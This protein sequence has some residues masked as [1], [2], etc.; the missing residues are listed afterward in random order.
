MTNNLESQR[1]ISQLKRAPGSLIFIFLPTGGS[2]KGGYGIISKQLVDVRND[3]V[4]VEREVLTTAVAFGLQDKQTI[5]VFYDADDVRPFIVGPNESND[6]NT[7]E[8]YL[9]PGVSRVEPGFLGVSL[10]NLTEEVIKRLLPTNVGTN[11]QVLKIVNDVPT[12]SDD[13]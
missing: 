11:G 8:T 9:T 6:R 7:Y 3:G 2:P 10:A 12:W 4:V 1:L 13:S 5:Y